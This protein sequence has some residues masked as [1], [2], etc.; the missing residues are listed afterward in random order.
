MTL[1]SRRSRLARRRAVLAFLLTMPLSWAG[2]P[3]LA[4]NGHFLHGVGAVNSSL[5]GA[6]VAF[7]ADGLGSLNLNPA[8]LTEFEGSR[9]DFGVE[10]LTQDLSV[11][12]SIGPFSGTTEDDTG[13][14]TLPAFSWVW[15]PK[16]SRWAFGFGFLALAG[17]QTNYP[18]DSANPVLAPQPQGFGRTLADYQFARIPLTLAYRATD[19]LSLGASLSLGRAALDSSPFAGASPDCTSPVSCFYPAATP[20]D[21][22]MG[23]GVQLGLLYE[24]SEKLALGL[25]YTSKHDFESFEW[26]STVAHPGRPDFGTARSFEFTLDSP[27]RLTAG[28]GLRPR[29]NWTLALDVTW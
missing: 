7:A 24:P 23:F 4:G 10:F 29:P 17:F 16:D 25:S 13:L 20:Q 1:Y 8:L 19:R 22:A 18:Q 2:A 26:N 5:G 3:A 28:L 14:A 9:V 15:H 12:S 21:S 6:G 11:S 27:Q